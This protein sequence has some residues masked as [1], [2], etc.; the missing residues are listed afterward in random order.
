MDVFV[1]ESNQSPLY[2]PLY[3]SDVCIFYIE[4]PARANLL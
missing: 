3:F 2:S 4:H 1:D